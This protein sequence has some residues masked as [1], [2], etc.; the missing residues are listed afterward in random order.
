MPCLGPLSKEK[1]TKHVTVPEHLQTI[2]HA[3][4][5]ISFC[6]LKQVSREIRD[7]VL[8]FA[9]K[10]DAKNQTQAF[11]DLLEDIGWYTSSNGEDWL[12]YFCRVLESVQ[13]EKNRIATQQPQQ[14]AQ[15][16]AVLKKII[17]LIHPNSEDATETLIDEIGYQEAKSLIRYDIKEP[18][19]LNSADSEHVEFLTAACSFLNECNAYGHAELKA[20]SE[21]DDVSVARLDRVTFAIM[22]T[23]RF[24]FANTVDSYFESLHD[25]VRELKEL[26]D[27]TNT[28][29]HR[30]HLAVLF[31]LDEF[32]EIKQILSSNHHDFFRFCSSKDYV[33]VNYE[34]SKQISSGSTPV[35]DRPKFEARYL[36]IAVLKSYC[37]NNVQKEKID[38]LETEMDEDAKLHLKE[39]HASAALEPNTETLN[40]LWKEACFKPYGLF[41]SAFS[42][43]A[44]TNTLR[45][46]AL[47]ESGFS[48]YGWL[49][50]FQ[51]AF[52]WYWEFEEPEQNCLLY[53]QNV[54][55]GFTLSSIVESALPKA[56]PQYSA[57]KSIERLLNVLESKL[58]LILP[59]TPQL[60]DKFYEVKKDLMLRLKHPD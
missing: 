48:Y 16:K 15:I 19:L 8:Q 55:K 13:A 5:W 50:F 51:K 27:G 28:Q 36:A 6:Q 37:R 43:L 3:S 54:L 32:K 22:N 47:V 4:D 45:D 21:R 57:S 46:G 58:E 20:V 35:F 56:G 34:W 10:N 17:L 7:S 38:N 49:Y 23:Y 2:F 39:E 9:E 52:I 30:L 12:T 53:M 42:T 33:A 18:A 26:Y 44:L 14:V 25:L 60:K 24:N 31:H 29:G 41:F 11:Q 1:I 40:R 59:V